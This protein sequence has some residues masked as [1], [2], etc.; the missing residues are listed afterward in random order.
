MAMTLICSMPPHRERR[1]RCCTCSRTQADGPPSL[2]PANQENWKGTSECLNAGRNQ[3]GTKTDR[4]MMRNSVPGPAWAQSQNYYCLLLCSVGLGARD[5]LF[6]LL[7]N[8]GM[9]A[10]QQ[11]GRS[12]N[13]KWKG[14]IA[15]SFLSMAFL[16]VVT[17]GGSPRMAAP[18]F[19]GSRFECGR[20]KG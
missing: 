12:A 19:L 15:T 4:S 16:R 14:R 18:A 9:R 6:C 13:C 20:D 10:E 17:C 5:H 8:T 1:R 2:G 7:F 11:V 3:L